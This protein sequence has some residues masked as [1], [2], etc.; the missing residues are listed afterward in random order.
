MNRVEKGGWAAIVAGMVNAVLQ[1]VPMTRSALE[2]FGRSHP[3]A[4]LFVDAL[5]HPVVTLVLVVVGL[6]FIRSA[7]AVSTGTPA[8]EPPATPSIVNT[9]SPTITN[10]VNVPHATRSKFSGRQEVVYER[11]IRPSGKPVPRTLDLDGAGCLVLVF[12][13]SD[14]VRMVITQNA[15]LTVT[16]PRPGSFQKLGD[17]EVRF[18][19]NPPSMTLIDGGEII[20]FERSG[21][22][23]VHSVKVGN[24]T[25]EVSLDGIE[26]ESLPRPDMRIVYRF[27]VRE[28]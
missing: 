10:T 12:G 26:R 16:N 6:L 1:W 21:G 17:V 14:E 22:K 13:E 23:R 25:F 18:V 4:Q 20:V 19:Q 28:L 24:R 27:S 11:A 15:P 7:R 2:V 9:F 3:T 8:A 5:F